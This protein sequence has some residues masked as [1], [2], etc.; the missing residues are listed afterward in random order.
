MI[1]LAH[2]VGI[3]TPFFAKSAPGCS[4]SKRNSIAILKSPPF[5][6]GERMW[7]TA[8]ARYLS[9]PKGCRQPPNLCPA[10]G[11]QKQVGLSPPEREKESERAYAWQLKVPNFPGSGLHYKAL[12]GT[13]HIWNSDGDTQVRQQRQG[14]YRFSHVKWKKWLRW[15]KTLEFLILKWNS[16]EKQIESASL[17]APASL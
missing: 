17:R 10:S 11:K 5:K 15:Q 14:N 3:T 4:C 13:T 9:T 16:N 2:K 1:F 8:Q 7:V 6:N 12:Y